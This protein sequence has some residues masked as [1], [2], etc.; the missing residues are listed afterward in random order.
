MGI[1]GM[2]YRWTGKTPVAMRHLMQIEFLVDLVRAGSTPALAEKDD[3]SK[4]TIH[5]KIAQAMGPRYRIGA[6]FQGKNKIK[7]IGV[8]KRRIEE[9]MPEGYVFKGFSAGVCNE[10]TQSE[11]DLNLEAAAEA[12]V[13]P[14]EEVATDPATYAD[15]VDAIEECLPLIKNQVYAAAFSAINSPACKRVIKECVNEVMEER[16]A[17]KNTAKAE[18]MDKVIRGFGEVIDAIHRQDERIKDHIRSVLYEMENRQQPYDA[19][20]V[21]H[22]QSP[23]W[24]RMV[25]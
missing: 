20:S 16:E 13:S 15:V 23:W 19:P 1:Q 14:P 24:K 6:R 7:M 9:L 11:L 12:Q 21:G 4:S 5:N 17:G 10:P 25:S 18:N 8:F 22:N 3:V 2:P